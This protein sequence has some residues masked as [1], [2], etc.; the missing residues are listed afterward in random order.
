MYHSAMAV[1]SKIGLNSKDHATTVAVLEYFFGEKIEKS[2][3]ER[4]NELKSKLETVKI[5]EKYIDYLWKTKKTR[6]TIQYGIII[7]YKETKIIINNAREFATKI[8][9]LLNEINEDF[10]NIS[11]DELKSLWNS[12]KKIPY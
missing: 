6:E 11:T 2:L 4:F 8:K 7:A 9:L 1:L 5:E 3:L 10:V 12:A